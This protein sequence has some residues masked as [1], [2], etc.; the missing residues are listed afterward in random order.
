MGEPH[1]IKDYLDFTIPEGYGV[2]YEYTIL[3]LDKAYIGQTKN[4]LS[5]HQQH[6]TNTK[7]LGPYISQGDYGLEILDVVPIEE[8]DEA[9]MKYIKANKTL[10]PDGFNVSPGGRNNDMMP[11]RAKVT[12]HSK[13]TE[14]AT[15]LSSK[16]VEFNGRFYIP[17]P[18]KYAKIVES[19]KPLDVWLERVIVESK[20]TS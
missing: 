20:D 4:I 1:T 8:L 15:H 17:I 9:E 6:A 7:L 18:R 19:E 11:I 12:H 14:N 13:P 3:S 10:E 2:I 16:I 5:R